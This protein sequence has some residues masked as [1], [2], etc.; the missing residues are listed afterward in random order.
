[1]ETIPT[2]S[3]F[4]NQ[5]RE[6]LEDIFDG[7]ISFTIAE[8]FLCNKLVEFSKLHCKEQRKAIN[9]HKQMNINNSEVGYLEIEYKDH[10][11][12]KKRRI[13]INEKA[14]FNAYPLSNIK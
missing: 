1:M 10:V 9:K 11:D 3:D 5:D 13:T 8:N 7:K 14:I 12:G 4:L 6:M 2:A